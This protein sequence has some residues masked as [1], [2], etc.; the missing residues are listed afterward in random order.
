VRSHATSPPAHPD[1]ARDEC[2]VSREKLEART[3]VVGVVGQGYVGL[4]LALVLCEASLRVV[5]FAVDPRDI[6]AV[7]RGESH[8]KPIGPE[9]VTAATRSGRYTATTDC[10]PLSACDEIL[11]CVPTSPTSTASLTTPPPIQRARRS[12]SGCAGIN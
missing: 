4:P 12:R 8:I 2:R 1:R 5:G 6:D 3:A 7:A 11:T 9:C 10:E